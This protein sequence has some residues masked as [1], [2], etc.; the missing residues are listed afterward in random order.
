[1]RTPQR[2]RR[3]VLGLLL[4]CALGGPVSAQ[5]REDGGAS[6][7]SGA[8][9]RGDWELAE[10]LATSHDDAP[11]LLARAQLAWM[12][13]AL[14]DVARYGKAA[15]ERGTT[16]TQ[17]ADGIWWQAR[18]ERARGQ[19]AEAEARLRATLKEQPRHAAV[20]LELGELLMEQGK[21]PEAKLILDT[22]SS[23]FNDGQL[24]TPA[25]LVCVARG[26]A[27]LGSF[28]DANYAL[29]RALKAD[30]KDADTHVAWGELLLEKYNIADAKESFADALKHN[31]N[32]PGAL[33]G[34]AQAELLTSNQT[35]SARD[36]LERAEAVAP[37]DP[38]LLLTRA[39]L[40]IMADLD[41]KSAQAL[42]ARVLEDRP[43]QLEAMTVQ[44]ICAY[45]ADD[46]AGFDRI[47]A[48]VLAINPKYSDFF[49][50]TGEYAVRVFR[51]EPSLALY[52]E[53][54]RLNPQDGRG[55]LGMATSLSRVGK[56]DE[57]REYLRRAFDADPYNVRAYNMLE[58][59]E[60]V[61]PEYSFREYK[62]FRLR[63]HKS[64]RELLELLVPPLV[65][66]AMDI[67]NKKYAYKIHDELSLEIY[68]DPQAFS[69]R[70]AGLPSISP[71][72]VCFGKVVMSRS[73]SDGNFNWAQVIWHEL[74]HV[75]HIQLSDYHVSRWFTEGLAEYETNVMDPAWSRHYDQEL[76][77][78]VFLDAIPS[79]T[80]YDHG[81]T[82][83]RTLLGVVRAY[84]LASL[85]IHF[86]AETWGFEKLPA[87]LRGWGD[88]KT[89]EQVF[90]DVLGVT[91][92]QFDARFLVWLKARYMTFAN[93]LMVDSDELPSLPT[94]E[95][96]L[97]RSNNNPRLWAQLALVQQ[98]A[99][100]VE[101]GEAA[102]KRALDL[103]PS[104]PTIQS[105]AM[106]HR[107]RAGR[108]RD[109]VEH[110]KKVLEAGKDSYA[111]RLVMGQ[112]MIALEDLTWARVHLEAAVTQYEDGVDAWVQLLW[113]GKNTGDDALYGRALD[114]L[115]LLNQNDPLVPK[116]RGELAIKQ[117]KWPVVSECAARWVEINPF[118]V[119]SHRMTLAAAAHK[120][121][122]ARAEIAWDALLMLRPE[123]EAALRT[124]AAAYFRSMGDAKR[125][126]RFSK[127]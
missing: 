12:R 124:E 83:S 3:G 86:I 2:V 120:K 76:A 54:I 94:L 123:E 93:Q 33:V 23:Q 101:P 10:R 87:M 116:L 31:P 47:K 70:I 45:I 105:F 57:A 84:H 127:P 22:F 110:G 65:E 55:L 37:R 7:L 5:G 9:A 15:E 106:T 43:R 100:K 75:Y 58:L 13:G 38:K 114:R 96:A 18:V 92:A 27:L 119:E 125:A 109:A 40:A 62:R 115:Y 50:Y 6:D 89:Q 69:V 77:S 20:R 46:M 67:Y 32:H 74:A 60:K 36:Y 24:K 107:L 8:L 117:G 99:G 72:G 41:C 56:E 71:Q 4:V 68:P 29:K 82:Q 34:L 103:A 49:S 61:I 1:V 78:Q 111:L 97:V 91:Y 25:E 39:H 121:D 64:Q 126:E 17:R 19:V 63:T 28:D 98:A 21:R 16:P 80:E 88:H 14:G 35:T 113:L 30:P 53:A 118:D 52:K 44:G 42:A 81:F 66:R 48:A 104:D 112:A 95:R 73:P 122:G 108:V 102:L 79:V 51:Y 90:A 59:Y 11:A 26:M 85:A